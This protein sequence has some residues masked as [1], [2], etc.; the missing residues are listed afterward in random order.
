MTTKPQ[1]SLD[2][3]LLACA[4][5]TVPCPV[6]HGDGAASSMELVG[7]P[8]RD[9]MYGCDTCTS[10]PGEP[11]LATGRTFLFPDSVR[12]PCPCIEALYCSPCYESYRGVATHVTACSR[13]Q[14][15]SWVPATGPYAWRQALREKDWSIKI[16]IISFPGNN[17][18]D[19]VVIESQVDDCGSLVQVDDGLRDQEAELTAVYR[20]LK[21]IPGVQL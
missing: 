14:G 11:A 1:P 21:Q 19:C 13:C 18:G 16:T 7:I 2:V 3:L 20:M 12:L 15:R 9:P 5:A 10:Q 4:G 6:C 17:R 8:G